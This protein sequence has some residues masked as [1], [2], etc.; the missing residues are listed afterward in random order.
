MKHNTTILL[1]SQRFRPARV[2]RYPSNSV[3]GVIIVRRQRDARL[4][5]FNIFQYRNRTSVLVVENVQCA[6]CAH[7]IN[8]FGRATPTEHAVTI[9]HCYVRTVRKRRQKEESRLDP[10][11]GFRKVF[12]RSARRHRRRRCCFR[13]GSG[14][15]CRVHGDAEIPARAMT[16]RITSS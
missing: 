14:S 15:W 5:I 11:H 10:A 8:A 6:L 4:R 12:V 16:F 1:L 2:S 13:S 7:T 3:R 9:S